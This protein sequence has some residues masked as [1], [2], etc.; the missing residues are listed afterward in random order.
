MLEINEFTLGFE[1]NKKIYKAIDR[2]S[3]SVD[4]GE[5]VALV[6][7]SGCG[8]SITASSVLGLQPTNSIIL[9]GSISLNGQSLLNL[10]AKQWSDIR[11]NKISMIFQE[12]MTALNPII[13]VGKQIRENILQHNIINKSEAK[14][15]TKKIMKLVGLADT[16]RLYN[17]YP[18][19]LSGGMRQRIMIAMALANN[20]KLLVADEPT[21]ALDVTIQAQIMD[22]IK[23]MNKEL[24]TAV[25]LISHDL[26]VIKNICDR[27]YIMYA[28]TIVESGKV[29][30]V[31]Q[32]PKHPYT[33]GLIAA[34][35]SRQR[36]NQELSTIPGNVPSLFNRNDI[37]C[38]FYNRCSKCQ[39]ICKEK[40]P[41]DVEIDGS[42]VNCHLYN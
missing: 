20:P 11:G 42:I 15:E 22:L 2:V 40:M 23:A 21:T 36:R 3:I 17:N 19:Q 38:K 28:G 7:E 4:N 35:P 6:G 9:N 27:V 10:D 41:D 24:G 33:Q 37:G 13:K 14:K 1:N 25:L 18:Y 30:N 26:G 5:I 29:N 34:I 12:P 32:N 16:D 8:K 39:P 31:M